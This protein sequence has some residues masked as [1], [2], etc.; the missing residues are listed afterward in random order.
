V[1]RRPGVVVFGVALGAALG[2]LGAAARAQ[3]DDAAGA[4]GL[5]LENEVVGRP[6][7]VRLRA[8][9][10]L[11]EDDDDLLRE[12]ADYARLP[13]R[14]Y[15]TEARVYQSDRAT[16]TAS[17]SLWRNPQGMDLSQW[18][19]KAWVPLYVEAGRSEYHLTLKYRERAADGDEQERGSWLIGVDR[20][21][22]NGLYTY[23]QF[24]Y[25]TQEGQSAGQDLYEY[26]SWSPTTKLRFGQQASVS[27]V[28][29]VEAPAP[30]YVGLFGTI[31]LRPDRTSLRVD[32]R[33]Y[34]SGAHLAYERYT[35]ALYQR[36][37]ER[38]LVR[39]NTR[40]YSDNADFQSE[41]FGIKVKRFFSPRVAAHVG[42]R[43]YDHSSSLDFDTVYG[44]LEILL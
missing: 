42:Y 3:E 19:W 9:A 20:S 16:Y 41:A 26:V 12:D 25:S 2:V 36:L 34:D 44:G 29:G 13:T 4:G 21:S 8:E 38:T 37:G 40:L 1:R 15:T 35:L 31:F 28:P 14:L 10:M 24:R 32:A 43:Y 11:T 30:W 17:Y 23:L 27:V 18:S 33:H 22:A 5:F 6:V 39:L 7:A